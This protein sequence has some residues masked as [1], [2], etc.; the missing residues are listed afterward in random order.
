MKP[1]QLPLVLIEWQDSS[2]PTSAWE[3]VSKY[4]PQGAVPCVSVGY[5]VS[6]KKKVKALASNLGDGGMQ[7]SGVIHIPT[8]CI[9]RQVFLK[10]S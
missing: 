10:E 6:D 2:Q 8:C 7:M 4:T 9:T 5:L 3:W 1:K